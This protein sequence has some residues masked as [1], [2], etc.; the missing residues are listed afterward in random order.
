MITWNTEGNI[1]FGD[2]TNPSREFTSMYAPALYASSTFEYQRSP[3][4]GSSIR[5]ALFDHEEAAMQNILT[6]THPGMPQ[7]FG[8]VTEPKGK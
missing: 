4:N 7:S 6:A 1:A 5:G 8:T 2:P 3:G